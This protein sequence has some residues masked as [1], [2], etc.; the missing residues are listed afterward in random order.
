MSAS[1][2]R[3]EV[4]VH[5]GHSFINPL[6][7]LGAWDDRRARERGGQ[8]Q[9]DPHPPHHPNPTRGAASRASLPVPTFPRH[10]VPRL[11]LPDA[12]KR[13]DVIILRLLKPVCAAL[14]GVSGVGEVGDWEGGGRHRSRVRYCVCV[15]VGERGEAGEGVSVCGWGVGAGERGVVLAGALR[16]QDTRGCTGLNQ[17]D[18]GG[19]ALGILE[20][21]W[22]R[23][24]A[25]HAAA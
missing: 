12:L 25:Q 17:D 5:R 16:D 21:R 23:R 13:A 19:G 6:W 8:T 11:A 7:L 9:R 18:L 20:T 14:Q 1:E 10:G 22:K 2:S 4:C 24:R 3:C 15:E